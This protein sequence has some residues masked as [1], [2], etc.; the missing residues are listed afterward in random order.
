MSTL[1]SI[2]SRT[3]ALCNTIF[4]DG[5]HINR[6]LTEILSF[7]NDAMAYTGY[8]LK[9]V[10]DTG[11]RLSDDE[12]HKM[13]L[14]WSTINLVVQKLYGARSDIESGSYHIANWISAKNL[15]K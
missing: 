11:V 12:Y 3:L 15:I 5:E 14:F 1:S 6:L 10:K 4:K 7:N 9:S 13:L 8:M 2:D